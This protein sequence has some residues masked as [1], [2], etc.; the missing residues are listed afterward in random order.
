MSEVQTQRKSTESLQGQQI[1]VNE[2]KLNFVN[3]IMQT[4]PS[5][6]VWK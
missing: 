3:I 6:E 2:K 5:K 4:K 1:N